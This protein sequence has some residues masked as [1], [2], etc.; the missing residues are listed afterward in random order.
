MFASFLKR[1]F[2]AFGRRY[3]YD[4]GYLVE[5]AKVDGSGAFKLGLVSQFTGHQFGL[6]ADVYYAA[7]VIAVAHADCGSCLRLAL[8]MAAEAGVPHRHLV[9]LLWPDDA[10]PE[11]MALAGRYARATVENLP[12]QIELVEKCRERWGE[13]GL[14]GLAAAT[15]SGMFYPLLKRGMGHGNACEPVLQALKTQAEREAMRI[16]G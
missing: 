12:E 9:A 7:K 2:A 13:R 3:D 1:Q 5:L 16:D 10:V 14:A 15:V 6:P 11:D 4:T 8:T